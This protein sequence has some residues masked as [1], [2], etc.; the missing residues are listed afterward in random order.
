M[1]TLNMIQDWKESG[2]KKKYIQTNACTNL[3]VT[4][5]NNGCDVLFTSGFSIE[6]FS[7]PKKWSKIFYISKESLENEWEEI[8][9]EFEI[10]GAIKK[11]HDGNIM[12]SLS[13]G[14]RFIGTKQTYSEIEVLG[15]WIQVYI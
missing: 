13:S 15:K 14:V 10:K 6:P 5:F 2:F 3:P 11:A 7:D 8:V 12:L 4:V 9:E 1:K